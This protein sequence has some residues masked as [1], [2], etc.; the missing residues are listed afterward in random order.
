MIEPIQRLGYDFIC[1]EKLRR[2]RWEGRRLTVNEKAIRSAATEAIGG[3]QTREHP[4][5]AGVPGPQ[6]PFRLSWCEIGRRI[7]SWFVSHVEYPEKVGVPDFRGISHSSGCGTGGIG[8]RV[9]SHNLMPKE[10]ERAKGY[11]L[12]ET[13]EEG[14][15]S[16]D[17]SSYQGRLCD[18]DWCLVVWNRS[19]GDVSGRY[20]TGALVLL[21]RVRR[22]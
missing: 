8:F 22:S 12:Y 13:D 16:N 18:V 1:C 5:G 4:G 15:Y 17:Q 14:S 10:F 2:G 7:C 9:A 20:E 19:L 11:E 21:C 3:S 6:G